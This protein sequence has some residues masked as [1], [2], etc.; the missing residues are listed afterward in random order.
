MVRATDRHMRSGM[1]ALLVVAA[2]AALLARSAA[3]VVACSCAGPPGPAEAA[4]AAD[5]VFVGRA[6]GKE[7]VWVREGT[8]PLTQ[9][10][11]L[12]SFDV[13]R[14]LKGSGPAR[15]EVSDQFCD[16]VGGGEPDQPLP[17]W[18][19]FATISGPVLDTSLCAGSRPMTAGVKSE[20]GAGSAPSDGA[21][22][23]VAGEGAPVLPIVAAAF[24]IPLVFLLGAAFMFPRRGRV[25]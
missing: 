14:Y 13:E 2:T 5:L 11:T 17:S 9:V 6:T 24:A 3:P 16:P 7:Y 19:I 15:L 8:G 22:F 20:L 1:L 12:V 4:A 18:V 21:S 10:S 23:D 25:P